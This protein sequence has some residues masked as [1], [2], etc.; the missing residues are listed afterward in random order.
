MA[1]KINPV[2][3]AVEIVGGPTRAANICGVSSATVHN[4]IK[5]ERVND[6][7]HALK[8]AEAAGVEIAQ[9]AGSM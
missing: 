8:L 3:E 1:K 4:W 6:L 2:K 7:V 9:L 5:T